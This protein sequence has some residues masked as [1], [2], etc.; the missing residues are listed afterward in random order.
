MPHTIESVFDDPAIELPR[1]FVSEFKFSLK[2]IGV[3]IRI[4]I[5][6]FLSSS[7]FGF[8]QSHYI[9]TPQQGG[10]YRPGLAAFGNEAAA[11]HQAVQ[12]IMT[13]YEPAVQAGIEPCDEWMIP[14]QCFS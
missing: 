3:E 6:R 2:D 14:N 1:Q 9:K 8:E 12:S 4:K 7:K 11:L 10:P 5:Y 13:H